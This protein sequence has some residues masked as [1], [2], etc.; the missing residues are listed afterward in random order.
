MAEKM[1]PQPTGHEPQG[2]TP[3]ATEQA[4]KTTNKNTEGTIPTPPGITVNGTADS[5]KASPEKPDSPDAHAIFDER[6]RTLTDP[7]GSTCEHEGIVNA[8]AIIS[9]PKLPRQPI[10]FLRGS[11]YEAAKMVAALLRQL[12]QQILA[13]ISTH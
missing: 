1:I 12:Q 6:F 11:K 2:S 7:F 9:D 5:L 3:G 13:E 8:I 10:V 4:G